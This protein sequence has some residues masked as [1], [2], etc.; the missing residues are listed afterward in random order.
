MSTLAIYFTGGSSNH[1][2]GGLIGTAQATYGV[3]T[4]FP[5]ITQQQA[6]DGITQYACVCVKNISPVTAND[7]GVY[8]SQAPSVGTLYIAKGLTGKNSTTEQVIANQETPP[9]GSLVFYEPSFDYDTVNIGTLN[10]GDFHHIWMKLVTQAN[11]PGDA[12][13]FSIKAVS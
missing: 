5:A 1:Y 2:R 13:K 12:F 9:T 11:S 3:D 4:V 8:I 6:K 7:V 10:A